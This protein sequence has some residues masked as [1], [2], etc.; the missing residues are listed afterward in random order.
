VARSNVNGED[1]AFV[2]DFEDLGPDE[3]VESNAV[4]VDDQSGSTDSDTHQLIGHALP[5]HRNTR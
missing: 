2:G 1:V 5:T 3:A 4:L